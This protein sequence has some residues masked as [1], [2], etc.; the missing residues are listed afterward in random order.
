MLTVWGDVGLYWFLCVWKLCSL[1]CTGTCGALRS[2]NPTWLTG[3][4]GQCGGC[5]SAP[6]RTSS[7][8]DTETVSPACSCQVQFAHDVALQIAQRVFNPPARVF[9][10]ASLDLAL[11]GRESQTSTAWTLIRTAASSSGRSGRWK[12]CWRR[13]SQSSSASTPA[14]WDKWTTRPCSKSTRTGLKRWWV[15]GR[16]FSEI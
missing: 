3:F 10:A 13:S 12:L 9:T 15:S 1:R 2:A 6:L 7:G 11:Q 5:T 16:L 14:S 4:T 8:W